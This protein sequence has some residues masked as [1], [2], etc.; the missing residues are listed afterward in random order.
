VYD[1]IPSEYATVG[2]HAM[3]QTYKY[4]PKERIEGIK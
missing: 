1:V 2:P 3:A 4:T